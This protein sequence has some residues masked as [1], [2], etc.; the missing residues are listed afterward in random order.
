MHQRCTSVERLKRDGSTVWLMPGN[1]ACE[2][3]RSNAAS[4]LDKVVSVMRS[5]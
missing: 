4:V 5:W 1:E 2:P 3:I